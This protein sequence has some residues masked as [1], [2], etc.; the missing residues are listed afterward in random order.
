MSLKINANLNA[1]LLA[2][3][4][5]VGFIYTIIYQNNN[6]Y[7]G[8]HSI[9]IKTYSA[10]SETYSCWDPDTNNDFLFT[11]DD[12]VD[13]TICPPGQTVQYNWILGGYAH[14]H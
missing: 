1:E 8:K 3:N 13:H 10:A 12:I 2:G 7:C 6:Y 9:V 5:V 4:W 11:Y 14:C